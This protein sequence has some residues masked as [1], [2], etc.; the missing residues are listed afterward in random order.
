MNLTHSEPFEE[1]ISRYGKRKHEVQKWLKD[2][3]P[4]D[5]REWA[6]GLGVETF[7]GTSGR[8]FPV[9]MKTSPLLRA[10]LKRLTDSGVD[11]HLRHR[12]VGWNADNSLR[13]ETPEGEKS[14]RADAVVLALGGG[15]WARL[16]SDGAWV[17]WRNLGGGVV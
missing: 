1:F 6:C 17:I 12:W 10:W 16:G 11:F 13:F 2:F 3:T 14:V 4:D 15:S 7:V 9:G 5:L 8:V